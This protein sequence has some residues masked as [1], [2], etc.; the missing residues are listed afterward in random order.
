MRRLA[1]WRSRKPTH[2]VDAR[3]MEWVFGQP[4]KIPD[5]WAPI[6]ADHHWE[7]V[8]NDRQEAR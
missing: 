7:L 6:P 4:H 1:L 5:P 8:P 3:L 2:R